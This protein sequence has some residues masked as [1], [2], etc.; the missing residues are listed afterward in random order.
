MKNWLVAAFTVIV[1]AV[2]SAVQAK[3]PCQT[4]AVQVT[5]SPVDNFGVSGPVPSAIQPDSGGPYV[6]GVDGVDAAIQSCSGSYDLTV[7]LL[8]S[9]RSIAIHLA[10]MVGSPTPYT[11]AWASPG[12]AQ[13]V[14]VSF[15]NIRNLFYNYSQFSTYSFTTRMG[16]QL[17]GLADGYHFRMVNPFDDAY[18]APTD[19]QVN[20]PITT[21]NVVVWH[22][23]AGS[24]G[25]AVETWV[26][27]PDTT[28]MDL[29]TPNSVYVGGL[30]TTVRRT[31][32]SAGQYSVPFQITVQRK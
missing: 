10:D 9:K 31:T 3:G 32:V 16:S 20:D 23:A 1:A 28:Q 8:R 21:S 15:F 18:T 19:P 6:T 7:N 17:G 5:I 22:Y 25:Y 14:P 12:S 13:P 29:N 4:I 27:Y 26:V 24:N 30:I 2:P 11:P